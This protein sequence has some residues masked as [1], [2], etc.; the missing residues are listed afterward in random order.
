ME[1]FHRE[2]ELWILYSPWANQSSYVSPPSVDSSQ[3]RNWVKNIYQSPGK[4]HPWVSWTWND[5]LLGKGKAV[6][7][8]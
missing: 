7:F 5:L 3:S 4:G 1:L 6:L 8:P 2:G